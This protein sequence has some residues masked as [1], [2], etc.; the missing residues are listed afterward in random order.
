M[1]SS[2]S[3]ALEGVGTYIAVYICIRI[4]DKY[5]YIVLFALLSNKKRDWLQ[6]CMAQKDSKCEVLIK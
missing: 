4:H 3:A 6:E 1:Y 5:I 2:M